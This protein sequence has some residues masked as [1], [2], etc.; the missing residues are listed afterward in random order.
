MLSATL[1]AVYVAA[2]HCIATIPMYTLVYPRWKIGPDNRRCFLLYRNHD[3]KGLQVVSRTSALAARMTLF[4]I[5]AEA[6]MSWLKL[7]TR[8]QLPLVHSPS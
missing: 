2:I 7:H 5:P 6:E 3:D 8:S 4:E 1:T